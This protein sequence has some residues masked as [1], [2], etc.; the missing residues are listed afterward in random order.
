MCS[1]TAIVAKRN[2]TVP[3]VAVRFLNAPLAD[4]DVV[5][6]RSCRRSANRAMLLVVTMMVRLV[7]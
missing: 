4:E 2:R 3:Y 6:E 5:Q 1:I 7:S